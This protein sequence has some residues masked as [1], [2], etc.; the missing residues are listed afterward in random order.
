[1]VM[2]TG[3]LI[4]FTNIFF[5][6]EDYPYLNELVTFC[7]SAMCMV[8]NR[9]RYYML[10]TYLFLLSLNYSIFYINEYYDIS[11][12]AYLFYFPVILCVA[13][14]HNPTK[15]LGHTLVFFLLSFLFMGLSI[16]GEFDFIRNENISTHN[17]ELLFSYN[18]SISIVVSAMMV[19][20]VIK[21]IDNQNFQLMRALRKEKFNQ[22]KLSQAL[23]EKEV[24][25]SELH[26]RVKNNMSVISSLLNLQMASTTNEE[27]R[28]LLTESRNRVASMSL[29]HEKLY[30]KKDFSKIEFD[31]YVKELV[32]ELVRS[33]PEPIGTLFTLVPCGQDISVAIPAGLIIN[34]I[35]TNSLKHAFKQLAVKPLITVDLQVKENKTYLEIRDNGTG[36]DFEASKTAGFSLG[37][38]LIESL[39]EQIDGRL[40]YRKDNGS[41]YLLVF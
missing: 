14:L 32:T 31:Q 40:E 5:L 18:L 12:A 17:N 33:S 20:L 3:L 13:L 2:M 35:V 41:V 27:A 26:H 6:Q 11:T 4:G 25:L 34:E 1:M 24:M 21:V 38:S 23:N 10:A 28:H 8:L 37:L 36:F 19:I 22:E 39:V 9:Y 29:V 15:G 30:R 16:F 7:M